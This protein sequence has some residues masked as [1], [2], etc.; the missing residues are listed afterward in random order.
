MP[1]IGRHFGLSVEPSRG[2]FCGQDDVFVS[3]VPLLERRRN[4]SGVDEWQPRPATELNR[5]LRKHYGVPIELESKMGGLAGVCR[6]LN[7]G[8]VIHAQIATLHLQIPDPPALQKSSQTDG[9]MVNLARA[10]Q[11]SGLAKAEMGRGKTSSLARR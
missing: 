7:R 4:S 9:A 2:V 8:D 3:G 6:A 5:D 11:A 10:L 1:Q